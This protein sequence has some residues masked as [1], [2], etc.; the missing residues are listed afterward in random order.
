MIEFPD[1]IRTLNT[2]NS[3]SEQPARP[4]H[5]ASAIWAEAFMEIQHE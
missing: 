5:R 3:R 2:L 4:L 1:S